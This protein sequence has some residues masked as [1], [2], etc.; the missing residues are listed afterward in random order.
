MNS[1]TLMRC[2]G[3]VGAAPPGAACRCPGRRA[4]CAQ[5]DINVTSNHDPAAR[6]P[7]HIA[8]PDAADWGAK[9]VQGSVPAL[10]QQAAADFAERPAIAFREQRITYHDL[11]AAADQTA[12]GLLEM[13]VGRGDTVALYL[14]NTPWHPIAFFGA[15]RTGARLVHLS[16]LDAPRELALKLADSGARTLITTNLPGMLPA[17]LALLAQGAVDHVLIGD[18][19]HWGPGDVAPLPVAYDARLRPLP[20]APPPP[21]WPVIV[22][23]DVCLLQYTGGT[24]GMPKGAMLT[25]GN[26]TAAVSIYRNWTDGGQGRSGVPQRVIAVLPLFHIYAL[27]TLLLRQLAEGNE[28]LLHMRFDVATLIDDIARKRAAAFAGVPTMFIALVNHPD[29][30][31]ADFSSLELATC[32]GAP[33]PFEVE[34]RV[35]RLIGQRLGGGWGMT[36]TSPAGTRIPEAATPRPGLIGIPLPGLDMRVVDRDDPGR[37]LGPDEI[38]EFAIRGP[39]VFAGYWNRPEETAAAFHDG[40]FLTGD[41]GAMDAHGLCRILDRKKNMIISGGFNVY[42]TVIE[43]AI[44]EHPD[45]AEVIVIGIADAYRGQAAKAFVTLRQGAAPLTLETLRAFLA[46][47][48]GRHEMPAALELRDALPR[49]PAGKLLA[50]ALRDEEAAR[51]TQINAPGVSA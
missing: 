26:L 48:I 9:V 25:H 37:V 8:F 15:A 34:Q 1:A 14:P 43:N 38:G 6:R 29:A 11:A 46:E 41:I 44:Y 24:T 23:D 35:E 31:G 50:R 40:Y 42:P 20:Q 18:D 7:W 19:A 22:P 12:A 36:E 51:A 33:L 30:A 32:G 2:G 16:A 39:N 47:R 3:S 27:T 4:E 10:L 5:G 17:A 45:V 13:G 49:S 28:L 21:H